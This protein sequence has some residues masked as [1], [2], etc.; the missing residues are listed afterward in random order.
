MTKKF[1]FPVGATTLIDEVGIDVA[2][3]IADFLG[4]EF[5]SRFG[6]GDENVLREMVAAGFLG[7]KSGKGCYVYTPGVKD[8]PVNAEAEKILKKYLIPK[9]LENTV[10]EM[11]MRLASRFIN[12]AILCLQEGV[13]A[14]PVEGDIG[15]VF[16]LGFP[17]FLGGPFHYVDTY[18]ADKLV[19]WMDKFTATFGPEFEPCSLLRD[20]AKD[21]AKKFHPRNK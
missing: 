10:E 3:H 17:P 1:G 5:G 14:N 8:R 2:S 9:K 7:R 11:Q 15:A 16:G 19:Q 18:G 6:G 12:E 20:H 13:L 21:T 4:K